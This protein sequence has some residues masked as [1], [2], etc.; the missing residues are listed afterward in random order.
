[1]LLHQSLRTWQDAY[2]MS[3]PRLIQMPKFGS[4]KCTILPYGSEPRYQK[5]SSQEY[6]GELT[7]GFVDGVFGDLRSI[8]GIGAV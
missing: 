6:I 5:G 3:F 1:M 4:V 2:P 7:P 8:Y